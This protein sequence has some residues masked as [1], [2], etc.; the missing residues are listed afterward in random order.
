MAGELKTRLGVRAR[1]AV[2][3]IVFMIGVGAVAVGV[4][5]LFVAP[6]SGYEAITAHRVF[7]IT[8]GNKKGYYIGDAVI[9]CVGLVGVYLAGR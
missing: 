4:F 6:L 3:V 2:R 9:I 8:A 5:N 7:G 1:L